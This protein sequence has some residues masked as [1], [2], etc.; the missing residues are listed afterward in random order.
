[1]KETKVA[2]KAAKEAGKILMKYYEKEKF[3]KSKGRK[4]IVTR[5]DI[6]SQNKIISI[7]SKHFP[8]YGFIAEEENT[9][10][11]KE[12]TWV[13]DPLDGTINFSH[14]YPFFCVSIGLAGEDLISGVVY[15]PL[16]KELFVSE[17]GK[18][19]FLN[20]RRIE[21]S[22]IKNLEQS[23]LVTGFNPRLSK[24]H[25]KK[26]F[27]NIKRLLDV[28]VQSFRRDGAAALDLCYVACGRYDGF[29]ESSLKPWDAVA[30]SLLVREAGGI[31]TNKK[32]QRWNLDDQSIIAANRMI[33]KKL[34]KILRF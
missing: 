20:K 15:D 12:F 31:V 29:F 17:K 22:D 23:L 28:N 26:N 33:H 14:N 32:N 8:D 30:G 5:A 1:M 3:I 10:D 19:A 4:D 13:I 24:A 27:K 16:R 2:I 7:L 25:L 6:K 9:Y 21:V 11:K 34:M 18:G